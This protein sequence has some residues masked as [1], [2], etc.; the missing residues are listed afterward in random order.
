M[1]TPQTFPQSF[2]LNPRET[3]MLSL[4]AADAIVRHAA[5]EAVIARYRVGPK[6]RPL[7]VHLHYLRQKL[8]PRGIRIQSVRG[9]GFR[10]SPESRVTL[11]PY[12]AALAPAQAAPDLG[13]AAPQAA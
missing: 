5:L 4:F 1:G 12:L 3:E 9:A 7:K 13:G 8:G 11:A 6:G 10:L 2:A